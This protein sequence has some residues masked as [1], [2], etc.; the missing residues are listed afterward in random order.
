MSPEYQVSYFPRLNL[1]FSE[2]PLRNIILV[3]KNSTIITTQQTSYKFN[4]LPKSTNLSS[5]SLEK[6]LQRRNS[7]RDVALY[8]LTKEE[9]LD[10]F[11]SKV[12]KSI[13]KAKKSN[14]KGN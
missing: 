11:K 3:Q 10:Y 2:T 6:D 13:T 1:F 7:K 9:N 12:C 4:I 14:I 5:T 8:R